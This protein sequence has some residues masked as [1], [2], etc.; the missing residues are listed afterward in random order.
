M[1]GRACIINLWLTTSGKLR[2]I[3]FIIFIVF[4]GELTE[5]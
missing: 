5:G 2:I 3:S 4:M 1:Y